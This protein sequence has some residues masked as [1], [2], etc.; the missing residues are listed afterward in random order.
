MSTLT[1][2]NN[3]T[4]LAVPKLC[5]DGSNWANYEPRLCKVM[6]FRGL[7]RHVEGVAVVP[8]P[9]ALVD[10]VPV[11][12][13]GKIAA[14]EEQIE[15]RE[16]KIIEYKKQEYHAQYIILS[17]TSVC[18]G[19]KIKDLELAE[20]MWGWLNRMPHQKALYIYLMPKIS[21]TA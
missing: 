1:P 21:S 8:K 3:S 7:W 15:S 5:D 9:Y 4:T 16:T 11:L 12:A 17:T 2:N 19:A 18:L 6:G 10:G 13:D 20:D 14:T